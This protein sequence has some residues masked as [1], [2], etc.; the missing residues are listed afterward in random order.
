MKKLFNIISL[1]I[2]LLTFSPWVQAQQ[3][4]ISGVVV[5]Q[6]GTSL[7]G[8]TVLVK[9][10]TNGATTSLD[11]KYVLN[12]VSP[13]DTILFSFIGFES[14]LKQVNG[15]SVINVILDESIEMLAEVQIVAF[16]KQ[17]KESVIG[18]INT[19]KP[20]ELKQ[21]SSNLTTALAGRMSGIIAYQRSGE[22]GKDNAEFFIR[23]VTSFGYKN[24]PLILID[25][26]EVSSED[27][28][29]IEPDNIASFSI[30]KDAT[31]T[32]LY[33]ARGANGVVLITTKEGKKGKAVVS[34]RVETNIATPTRV[35]EFLDGVEYMELYNKALRTRNPEASLRYSKTKIEGT[36]NKLNPEAYPNVDWYNELFKN[37]TQNTKANLNVNGGGEVAQ[38]YLS[39]S[40]T[41]ETGLLKVDNLNNFNNNINIDRYNIRANINI[42]ITKTTRIAV[43]FS[44]LFDRYNGPINDANAIFESVMEANPV[45]FP[46][47]FEKDEST[48]Y[49][50]HT[51]FGN[52]AD[53][54][55]PNPY[56][57]MVKGYKDRFSSTILSQAQ[58]EQDLD[59]ITQGLK[60]RALA[61]IR[62]YSS[63]AHDYWFNP[64]YYR[65]V[66]LQGN[67]Y[68]VEQIVEGS[69]YLNNHLAYSDANSRMY[70]EGIL[71]YDREFAERHSIGALLVAYRSE[72]L[73]TL[74]GN[75]LSSF[76]SRNLGISGRLT[77]AFDSRYFTEF[78]FGYNGSEKFAEHNRFGFFPSV[79]AGWI[80]SNEQFW[81]PLKETLDLVKFKYTYGLVGNDAISDP[82]DRFF[83]LSDA[84]L[85]DPGRGYTLG[86]DFNNSYSGYTISR[87][88]NPNVTW[89]IAYKSNYGLELG[90]LS[91]AVFQVDYFEE[92]RENIY[93]PL[94]FVPET[95]GS[96]AGISSNI[97]KAESRG[98]DASLDINKAFIKGFWISSRLNFT[99]ATSKVLVNGEP[100]YEYEHMSSIGYPIG[101]P[102]GYVAQRLFVDDEEAINSPNQFGGVPGTH[103]GAGDIKYV[104]INKDGKVDETDMV[105]VGFPTVPEIVY[106]FGASMGYRG[107]DFS[108][109]FQGSG[110]QS[111]YIR[112]TDGWEWGQYRL[113]ATPFIDERN[114][115]QLIADNHWS[116]DNPDPYAF[117]PRLSVES[118]ENN[119]KASTWWLRDGSFIRLKSL[120]LGYTIP[121]HISEKAGIAKFRMYFS[122]VNLLTFSQFKLWDPE[123]AGNGL[124][125]P[126]QKVYN[127]GIQITL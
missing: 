9:G 77:Y 14:Q 72:A 119:Q 117:W 65:A 26:L 69:E 30:M 23:G 53:G 45:N 94:L 121:S 62:S 7:P 55:Y 40:Y 43:K 93:Q 24:S 74:G 95:M 8:V 17:K 58:L 127:M 44:S 68:S 46:K 124:G 47:Y 49:Y 103:Y 66:G 41:N 73:N 25:G 15:N 48:Q 13:T 5:D 125:Y 59:F 1:N 82:N 111:F 96:T 18:S 19:I 115:L 2:L 37:S 16:Q 61:S 91:T 42:G 50:N 114:A 36:R 33:G 86:R 76:P 21:P 87:Y 118:V 112:T 81:A 10:T 107:I 106:G 97:G 83:Y 116:D 90:V 31:A 123:M 4:L 12:N 102:R 105:P 122:G 85:N 84:N 71:Q 56:A 51:L 60:L 113:G 11:G 108:F 38:Y 99:Y 67:D 75:Y 6:E 100:E 63:N 52:Q 54:S 22:P 89:E 29:R 70:F 110:R 80:L 64:F 126:T 57:D 79:G 92:R 28:A 104:D 34:F 101:Q 20:A 32:S 39:T 120:E 78:N 27:L 35:N 88:S 3:G 109:F 98:V